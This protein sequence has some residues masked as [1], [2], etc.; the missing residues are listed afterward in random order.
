ME[1]NSCAHLKN[2]DAYKSAE[3][4]YNKIL[5]DGKDPFET[6]LNMQ[7]L[8]QKKLAEKYPERCMNPEEL[9][10]LG[11]KYDWVRDNKIAFDDEFSELVSALGGM[12]RSDKDRSAIWKKWKSNHADLRS[13]L[14]ANMS[15]EDKLELAFEFADALHFFVN[16]M[17][18]LEINAKDLFILYY[19][20]N[21]ENFRRY[22][23]NY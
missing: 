19:A 8:L 3:T 21:A 5:A 7:V 6:V 9:K 11:N 10:T 13:E 17:M 15:D 22:E 1:F 16:I 18:A 20:K 2:T 23:N 12:S 4:V 14:F